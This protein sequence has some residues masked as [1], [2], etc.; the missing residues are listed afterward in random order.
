MNIR[1]QGGANIF[2]GQLPI[3]PGHGLKSSEQKMQRQMKCQNQV[4]Y[5]EGQK[6][7]LKHMKCDS[8]EEIEKKLEMFHSYED[9]ITAAREAY[10]NEQMWHVLDEAREN[11]EKIAEEAKK[12]EPKTAEE[13]REEIAEE[14]QGTEEN[15]GALT[16][17]LEE[18]TESMDELNEAVEEEIKEK[19]GQEVEDD[20][21]EE[22]TKQATESTE[23]TAEQNV[24]T[25][26]QKEAE[27]KRPRKRLDIRI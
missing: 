23:I 21:T 26:I 7:N 17:E 20:T 16:E 12:L 27:S 18:A 13:R 19:L 4:D 11:G 5:W 10:N 2:S 14:A 25:E 9:Q 24:V 15:E 3:L 22:L 1:L 8:L 6:D